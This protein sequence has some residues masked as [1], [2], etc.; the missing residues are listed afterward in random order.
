MYPTTNMVVLEAIDI[1][2]STEAVT[3]DDPVLMEKQQQEVEQVNHLKKGRVIQETYILND[4]AALKKKVRWENGRKE[5]FNTGADAK[6]GSNVVVL[7]KTSFF[8][9]VKSWYMQDLIKMD[10]VTSIENAVGTKAQTSSSGDAFVEYALEVSFK[11]DEHIHAVKFTAYA[12]TCKIMIQPIG[13]KETF[14]HLDRKTVPRYFVDTFL[15]PW[16]GT[17]FANKTYKEDE[18]IDAINNE[19]VRLD[20][21]KVNNR[22]VNGLRGRLAST[23][24][25]S[26]EV[27]CMARTCKYTGLNLNN[28]MAVGVCNKCCCF[29]HFECSKTKQE[30]REK[31]LKGNQKYFCSL[32]FSQ[33]PTMVAFEAR[34]SIQITSVTKATPIDIEANV[35]YKCDKCKF[36][37]KDQNEYNQHLKEPHIIV[38]ETCQEPMQSK[39]AL[40]KHIKDHH[41]KPCITCDME[42][43]TISELKEHMKNSHGPNC[44]TCDNQFDTKEE[45][46]KHIAEKHQAKAQNRQSCNVCQETF[47]TVQDLSRHSQEKHT[48]KCGVCDESMNSKDELEKHSVVHMCWN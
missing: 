34:R 22:K 17:A 10:G 6:D 48:F 4:T 42:F 7:M 41:T 39:T 3:D 32:C 5:P 11:V 13:S 45:L 24:S 38:C 25:P 8:E 43:K 47:E 20:L 37:S 9:Y 26:A 40:N 33:N 15:L 44:T 35:V 16:C 12:T 14:E 36:E 19:I 28:K 21:L 29:E 2:V 27:K 30:D 18:M 23:P 46:E 31:I 1:V